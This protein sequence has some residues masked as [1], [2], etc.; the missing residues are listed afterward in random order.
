[1]LFNEA[2]DGL[3]EGKYVTRTAW[4]D[5]SYL[6]FLPGMMS[7]FKITIQPTVNVGNYL[8]LTVDFKADDWQVYSKRD[9]VPSPLGA[10]NL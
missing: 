3:I 5:G 4:T 10:Q 8:W 7:I 6:V 1:M 9:E 2:L